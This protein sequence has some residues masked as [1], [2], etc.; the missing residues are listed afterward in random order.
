MG[1]TTMVSGQVWGAR[2]RCRMVS[3]CVGAL[4]E[5][6][7]LKGSGRS[8]EP[9]TWAM[10]MVF[11]LLV[12]SLLVHSSVHTSPCWRHRLP[13]RQLNSLLLRHPALTALPPPWAGSAQ[14]AVT[15]TSTA[16]ASR[17][18]ATH[19]STLSASTT[20][21]GA[22]GVATQRTPMPVLPA[23]RAL[24]VSAA[25]VPR[26]ARV[27]PR[28]ARLTTTPSSSLLASPAA[29]SPHRSLP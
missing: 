12:A 27:A 13:R 24:Q 23:P 3:V 16:A 21:R 17:S 5:P 26:C 20:P 9:S 29:A 22:A 19:V 18:C 6:S 25:A 15:T 7:S 4:M 2:P 14:I 11:A 28:S 1:M 8:S 10:D